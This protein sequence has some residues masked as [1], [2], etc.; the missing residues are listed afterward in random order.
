[1]GK[2]NKKNFSKITIIFSLLTMGLIFLFTI[3][4]GEYFYSKNT[5]IIGNNEIK[6]E[7]ILSDLNISDNKNIFMYSIKDMKEK[8]LK[9]PYIKSVDIKRKLP[10]TFIVEIEEKIVSAVITNDESKFYIDKYGEIVEKTEK[11]DTNV[12]VIKA[13]YDI[14]KGNINYE[15]LEYSEKIP[16]I[17]ECIYNENLQNKINFIDLKEK[18]TIKII[19]KDDLEIFLSSDNN[20]SYNISMISSI[21]VDLQSQNKK[22]GTL[23]LRNGYALYKKD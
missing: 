23:D 13:Q 6:E 22:S 21:L 2:N 18:D 17:I 15:K 5:I 10:N 8:L 16:Y 14:I 20:I 1:M 11:N 19:T 4:T 9:N 12:L 7:K 3:F